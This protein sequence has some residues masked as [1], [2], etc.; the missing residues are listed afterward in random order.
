MTFK[1]DFSRWFNTRVSE[2]LMD[3]MAGEFLGAGIYRSV[4]NFLPD[5]TLVL[6]VET[7]PSSFAN[8]REYQMWS[9]YSYDKKLSKWFAPC[10]HLSPRG[11]F[12]LQKKV[13][14][15][16]GRKMPDKVPAMI[17]DGHLGNWGIYE[18]RVVCCDYGNNRSHNIAAKAKFV[19]AQWSKK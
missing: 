2:D 11:Q 10:V 18:D 15:I 17:E 4:Y 7:D 6:K 12:L 14:P 8:I 5:P 19:N 13:G 16:D 9:T 3:M 1:L